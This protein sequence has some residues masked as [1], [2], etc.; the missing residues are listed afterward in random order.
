MSARPLLSKLGPLLGLI[1]VFLFFTIAVGIHTSRNSFA[2]AGNVQ[3]IAL[4]SAIV[5]MATLGMTLIIISG[6]ID[7]SM[8][9]TVALTSVV[10]AALLKFAGWGAF[11][12]ALGA[13]VAGGLCGLVNG[14]LITGLRV[15]PFIVTLGSYLILRGAAK[16]IAD[17]RT[18]NPDPSALDSL[19]DQSGFLPSGV[20][21][22]ALLAATVSAIRHYTRFGRHVVAIGSNEQAAR[23]C[24]VPIGR[25][26]ILVYM[27]GGIFG[28][29]AGLLQYSRLTIGDPTSAPGLELD[30]I[31]AVV[32]GGGSLAGGEG[33]VMGSLVGAF[34]MTTIRNGCSQMGWPTWVTEIVAGAIIVIA[35]AL[36]RLRHRKVS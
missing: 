24:G 4:Q 2:T 34:F 16:G 3:T 35:V 5:G 22:L 9:S 28:G 30:V 23:L 1:G 11:P 20:W 21:M 6:G 12:A 26:K 19:L 32:I 25:T 10:V 14:L 27:L 33:S 17:E 29:L 15:V 13:V 18:I 36:D 7:L 31:A 8:G